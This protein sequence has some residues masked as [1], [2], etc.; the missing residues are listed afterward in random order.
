MAD[1][2]LDHMTLYVTDIAKSRA[3]YDAILSVLNYKVVASFLNDTYVCYAPDTK[4]ALGFAIASAPDKSPGA[5]HLAFSCP[6]S[7]AVAQLYAVALQNGGK[8]NGE[9]GLRE[10]YA[11]NYFAAF[12]CDPDGN[13]IEAMCRV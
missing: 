6:S 12:V 2:L 1:T 10:A 9:P 4:P 5:V 11:S 13:N 7:D 3:F 8:D